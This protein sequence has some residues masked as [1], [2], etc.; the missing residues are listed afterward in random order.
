MVPDRLR[1]LVGLCAAPLTI[2]LS[3]APTAF[4]DNPSWNGEYAITFMVGPKSGTS[5]A[6]GEPEGQ[7]TETYGFRS[8]CTSGKCVA[9]ILTTY[10]RHHCRNGRAVSIPW[11]SSFVAS[12]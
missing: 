12:T 8:S 9:S 5:M 11:S 4:A 3:L 10:G 2:A 1:S 6:V 7:H